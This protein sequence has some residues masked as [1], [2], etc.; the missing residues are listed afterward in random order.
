MNPVPTTPQYRIYSAIVIALALT[1]TLPG[2]KTTE[3]V[4][5]ADRPTHHTDTGFRNNYH[6]AIEKGPWSFIKAK[7]FGDEEFADHEAEAHLVPVAEPELGHLLQPPAAP[8][9]TWLGH[10]TFLIQY[11]GLN[12]LTDP[13]LSDR[14]SPVSFAGPKR[15]VKLPITLKDLPRIDYVVISHNH[16]DHLD[17]DTIVAL[18]NVPR[19]MVPLKVKAWFLEAG[20]DATRVDEFDWW[21][22]MQ[23]GELIVTA[24]PCQHW[25][26]RSLF[27]RNETLWAAWHLRVDDF[28]TWFGGDTGYNDIEFKQIREKLGPVDLGLIPI[29][30][31]APRWFMQAQHVD[32]AEAILIHRD[33]GARQS[34][35]MHW[36]TFEL[37]AERIMAPAQLIREAQQQGLI[38]DDE[39][40]TLP[41][42]ASHRVTLPGSST[43]VASTGLDDAH[44]SSDPMTP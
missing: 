43:Q 12:I 1:L 40:F 13:I 37:S 6:E 8:L 21:D 39:F 36:G 34:I 18:G 5:P 2:C 30:A 23:F 9:V 38:A 20:I 22:Q 28:S 29:G 7:Y 42:G 32:P 24:T 44:P 31:Y 4:P 27:D 17:M 10:S 26:A 41:V 25:S 11:R 16:Y 14:A 35:G 33:I 15:L 3:S 19:Y